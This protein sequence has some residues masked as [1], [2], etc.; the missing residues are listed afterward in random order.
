MLSIINPICAQ[1]GGTGVNG[2]SI[3]STTNNTYSALVIQGAN[4]PYFESGK[5]DIVFK[6]KDSGMSAVRAYRNGWY[7]TYLQFLTSHDTTTV[8]LRPRMHID[9]FGRVGI[10]TTN[11]LKELDVNGTIR[12]NSFIIT[13]GNISI[14]TAN[15]EGYKLAVN[16]IIGAAEI[17]VKPDWADFVFKKDYKLPTL[18]EVKKH[19]EE[20]GT[21]PGIP[22]DA[23][24]KANGVGLGE[25][26]ALLLQKIEELTLYV[27]KQQEEINELKEEI[28]N[29]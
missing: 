13:N 10:G 29:K 11:P 5:R 25:T 14:G 15:T 3:G 18:C 8:S 19:I 27:I 9:S 2:L 1:E 22:S 4:K 12:A 26:N 7:G 20:K 17:I 23:D 16:G 28:K 24:V 21:L 6:F